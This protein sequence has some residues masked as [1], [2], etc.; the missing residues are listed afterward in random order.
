MWTQGGLWEAKCTNS[1]ENALGACMQ[2]RA[3]VRFV[4]LSL[5]SVLVFFPRTIKTSE[6][7]SIDSPIDS[8]MDASILLSA[9]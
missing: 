8:P 2:L 7:E 9:K 4:L 1:F 3:G 6:R 5:S